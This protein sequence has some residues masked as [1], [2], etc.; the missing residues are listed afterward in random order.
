MEAVCQRRGRDTVKV[1]KNMV[2]STDVFVEFFPTEVP[3]NFGFVRYSAVAQYR[4]ASKDHRKIAALKKSAKDEGE[5]K[6][7]ADAIIKIEAEMAVGKGGKSIGSFF[8][9]HKG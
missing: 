4:G 1:K 2:Q 6:T 5:E 9:L 7:V 8:A 3:D